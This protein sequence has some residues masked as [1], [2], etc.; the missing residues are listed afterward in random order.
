MRIITRS[1]LLAALASALIA[2]DAPYAG[3]WKMNT[4][5]SNFGD[6]IMTYETMP[7][8]EIK[9][10]MDGMSYTF[11]ADGKDYTT[12]WGFTSAWKTVD[13]NTWQAANKVNG[14]TIEDGTVKLSADGKTL[15]VATKTQQANGGTSDNTTVFQ[16][17][18]GGPGLAG[19]WKTKNMKSSVPGVMEL[20]SKPDGVTFKFVND[21]ATCDAKFDGKD[22]PATGAMFPSGWTCVMAKSGDGLDITW[23]KDGKATYMSNYTVS[24]KTLTELTAATGSSDKVK[25]IWEKQ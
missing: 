5:K 12:P 15:T 1:V 24:G 9:A 7:G 23:K 13:A 20:I 25:I 10:T 8:G 22:Y 17:V 14:K 21:G 2:A 16:R 3:K 4:S 6:S 18:S 19:K 11:K